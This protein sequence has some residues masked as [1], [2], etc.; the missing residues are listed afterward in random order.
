MNKKRIAFWELQSLLIKNSRKQNKIPAQILHEFFSEKIEINDLHHYNA[1]DFW[2]EV[3]LIGQDEL[4]D[5]LLNSKF[6]KALLLKFQELVFNSTQIQYHNISEEDTKLENIPKPKLS[7][8]ELKDR[9]VKKGVELVENAINGSK[10]AQLFKRFGYFAIALGAVK[11]SPKS[12]KE[13]LKA[14]KEEVGKVIDI[15]ENFANDPRLMDHPF[16]ITINWTAESIASDAEIIYKF[17]KNIEWKE[18]LILLK[19]EIDL[20]RGIASKV[21][22]KIIKDLRNNYTN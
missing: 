22:P 1:I 10:T 20:N 16:K 7:E 6:S 17:F 13:K 21:N 4:I 5:S 14:W 12:Q 19:T 15:P 2:H 9:L 8:K 11:A 3:F 18:A